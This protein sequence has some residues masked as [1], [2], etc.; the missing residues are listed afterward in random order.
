MTLNIII[1]IIIMIMHNFY[2]SFKKYAILYYL[3]LLP[4]IITCEKTF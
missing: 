3:I 4:Y 1:F 2:K